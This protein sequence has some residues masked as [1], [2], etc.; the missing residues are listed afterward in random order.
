MN[1]R[2]SVLLA[3]FLSLISCAG[4]AQ[5][6]RWSTQG[7]LITLDPHSQNEILSNSI[8]AQVYETLTAREKDLSITH[9]LA[10]R[11]EQRSSTNWRIYLR[12]NVKFHDGSEFTADD[13]I[14]SV[15]RAKKPSSGIQSYANAV[16]QLVKVDNLTLDFNLG[17]VNPVFLEH[18][19]TIH[20][21][22]KAWSE[23]HNVVNPRDNK[24]QEEK[25]TLLNANGT[26]PFM[27]VSRQPDIQ[28]RFRKNANWWGKFDG[29]LQEVIYVPIKSDAARTAALL[30]GAVDLVLDPSPNDLP[31]L[32][33]TTGIKVIEGV[34][35][36]I[37]FIGF[38]Q[39]RDELLYSS[40]K[41]KNPF[42]DLAVRK[43]MY[44]A[45][46]IESIKTKLMRGQAIVTG[47][48]SPS[49]LGHGKDQE[50]EKR[51]PYDLNLARALMRQ[52]GYPDGF[53]VQLDC[54]NNR[55]INDEEICVALSAMWSQI[56]IKVRLN[57]MPRAVYF[58][59]GEK[60]D[61]SLYLLGWG[62]AF[63]DVEV[64]FTPIFRAPGVGGIGQ[65]NWGNMKNAKVEEL[66]ALSSIEPDPIK[67]MIYIKTVLKEVQDQVHYIPL[68]RQVIPWAMRDSFTPAH[69]ADNW[70]EWRWIT[71]K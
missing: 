45:I 46:D 65:W 29:N 49:A 50:L 56:G 67:R 30:S 22:S 19:S 8:N 62:G 16:G 42:K 4:Y 60:R 25:F 58:S 24:T 71:I 54:P 12:P 52:A 38:D 10:I 64:L 7:D 15:E 40:V 47:S 3:F 43:A 21:M 69:R 37:L 41:G 51:L 68:H 20:I 66:G 18:L 57:A 35:N 53:E 33:S 31:K 11:W 44:H 34:E 28:T 36:R 26:G 13:V 39:H 5:T 70:L 61:V 6:L 55:Y 23:K 9:A 1:L 17:K 2:Q 14:F 59:K 32:K 63:T 27:L 48:L